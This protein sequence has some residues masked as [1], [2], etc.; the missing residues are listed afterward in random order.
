MYSQLAYLKFFSA[1]SQ[2]ERKENLVA[3]EVAPSHRRPQP[4]EHCVEKY[5]KYIIFS[6]KYSSLVKKLVKMNFPLPNYSL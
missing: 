6:D 1:M 3:G 2:S 4:N 5:K